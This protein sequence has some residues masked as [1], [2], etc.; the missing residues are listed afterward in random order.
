MRFYSLIIPIYNRPTELDELLESLT[1]QQ[2]KNFEVIVL[3]DGS[4]DPC[5]HIVDKYAQQLS[6]RYVLKENSG[7]GFTRNLGFSLAQGDYFIVFDSDCIIPPQ[8]LQTVEEYLNHH[9]LDAF[10]GPDAAFDNFTNIQKA[11]SYSMTSLFTTG[12][13]RGGKKH[14]GTF[15]PRSFNMGISKEV[16]NTTKGYVITRMG[17]DIEF[18]IRI[19]RSGFKVGLIQE[20]YVYHK[21]RT[22][23]SQFFK[24][25]HFFGRAR[26]NIYRFYSNE[27]KWVHCLPALF[28]MAQIFTIGLLLFLPWDFA[29]YFI[30]LWSMY[31]LFIFI[32]ASIRL[33]NLSIAILCI[34]TSYIQLTAYGIGFMK[35]L[36]SECLHSQKKELQNKVLNRE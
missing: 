14:V 27:L 23:L 18:S 21:R 31:F 8:Y 12:G 1:Q 15:H 34:A 35:E 36:M 5:K 10:G 25:L 3:E 16:W 9:P 4:K 6:I 26:I 33:K 7:Q 2:F 30:F 17:E 20:A 11:I 13:I 32:D 29:K 28:L 22:S 19:M 24:Q